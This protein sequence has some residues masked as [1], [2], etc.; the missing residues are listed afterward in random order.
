VSRGTLATVHD[1]LR[2]VSAAWDMDPV[3]DEVFAAPVRQQMLAD[4][5]GRGYQP[6]GSPRLRIHSAASARARATGSSPRREG[7]VAARAKRFIAPS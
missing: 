5:A 7:V 1:A 3:L 2:D 4:G 6:L